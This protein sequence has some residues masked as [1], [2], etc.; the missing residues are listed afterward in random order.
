VGILPKTKKK[1]KKGG[2][3]GGKNDSVICPPNLNYLEALEK[4]KGKK[5]SCQTLTEKERGKKK[6]KELCWESRTSPMHFHQPS[7]EGGG[8]K[9]KLQGISREAIT[10]AGKKE[11]A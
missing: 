8:G 5:E 3:A 1:E 4:R 9:K 7:G 6:R 2:H 10:R 11:G